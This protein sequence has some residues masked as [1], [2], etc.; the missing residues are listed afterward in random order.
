M[1]TIKEPYEMG[2]EPYEGGICHRREDPKNKE[3]KV[4]ATNIAQLLSSCKVQKIT[5]KLGVIN[6]IPVSQKLQ[7][8][9]AFD[10]SLHKLIGLSFCKM[11]NN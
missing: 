5:T 11:I 4:V 3:T 9:L 8:L 10:Y 1:S 7:K 2:K 6:L